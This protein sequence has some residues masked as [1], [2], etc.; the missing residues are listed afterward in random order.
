MN[1]FILGEFN[2]KYIQA[3]LFMFFLY[4]FTIGIIT[5]SFLGGLI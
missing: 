3:L 1:H 2:D 4:L 5:I